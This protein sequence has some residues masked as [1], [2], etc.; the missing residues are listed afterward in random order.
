MQGQG[1]IG[2][3]VACAPAREVMRAVARRQSTATAH[4]RGASL[5]ALLDVMTCPLHPNHK[6]FDSAPH[7]IAGA[8]LGPPAALLPARG[9]LRTRHGGDLCSWGQG[10]AGGSKQEKRVERMLSVVTAWVPC[11]SVGCIATADVARVRYRP[12]QYPYRQPFKLYGRQ[13]AGAPVQRHHAA[14]MQHTLLSVSAA[15]CTGVQ[16]GQGVEV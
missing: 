8:Q 13:H 7:R 2:W 5:F 10:T 4:M 9:P 12:A 1:R 3:L 16:A 15:L 14:A 6:S 11:D